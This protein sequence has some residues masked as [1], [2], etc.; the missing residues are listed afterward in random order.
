MRIKKVTLNNF[1]IY[2]GENTIHFNDE[3]NKNIHL[4]IGEN[5]FGKTTFLTSLVWC[6]Y[7]NGMQDVEDV[8]RKYIIQ[9]GGYKHFLQNSLNKL[10]SENGESNYFVEITL[11]GINIPGIQIDN[12]IIRRSVRKSKEQIDILIDG[13]E[14]ELVSEIGKE[15]FIQ[16]FILPKEIAKFFFFDAEKITSLAELKSLDDKRKLSK[17]YSEVLGIKKYEDL[18]SNLLDIKYK[19]KKAGASQE[20]QVKLE[21]IEKGI[22]DNTEKQNEILLKKI[23]LLELKQ[24]LELESDNIQEKL[25]RIG[26]NL[27]ANQLDKL[28][29]EK[30][31]LASNHIS[32]RTRLSES[33]ELAPFAIMA[34][35][36]S[37]T[38]K[39]AKKE[40]QENYTPETII[41]F[42]KKIEASINSL[43]SNNNIIK[44]FGIKQPDKFFK[45]F[46]DKINADLISKNENTNIVNSRKIIDFDSNLLTEF[47]DLFL[48]I[49]HQFKSDFDNLM[50]EYRINQSEIS[51]NKKTLN[52][53]ESKEND[54]GVLVLRD[55]KNKIVN[56]IAEIEKENETIIV[57]GANLTRDLA[58]MNKVKSE[59]EN[60]LG[61]GE[62]YKSKYEITERLLNEIDELIVRIKEEKKLTLEKSIKETLCL[63]MHKKNFV[64]RVEVLISNDLIDINLYDSK[65]KLIGKEDLSKGEQQLYATSI[66]KALVDESNI[67]FPVFIDSPLQKLDPKHARNV[68]NDF[69]PI[70][71][72]QVIIIPLL[73]REL[74]EKEYNLMKKNVCDVWIIENLVEALYSTFTKIKKSELF[75]MELASA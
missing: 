59:L 6:L 39:N 67:E 70:I 51:T 7:G 31:K 8:Y 42:K 10:A 15:L 64:N 65:N 3:D 71:S 24:K 23:E 26:T 21:K 52:S 2:K 53:A 17:A 43:S 47:E 60:K 41:F 32:L 20:D 73:E 19:Y 14:N 27:S 16:D 49:K 68:I 18:K 5:G 75:N 61:V 62:Q 55:E 4:V 30:I 1:R 69:Y 56:R 46:K 29:K 13:D 44:E 11:E 28:R 35:E 38:L 63:L 45:Q 12:V 25:I 54:G 37:E 40:I 72:K 66:L 22:N 9:S 34:N 48:N 58:S 50:R 74:N 36:F 57:T 33:L